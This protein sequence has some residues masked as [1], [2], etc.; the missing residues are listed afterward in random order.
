MQAGCYSIAEY[1]AV[2]VDSSTDMV[3]S[4]IFQCPV[5]SF[6]DNMSVGARGGYMVYRPVEDVGWLLF[7]SRV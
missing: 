4:M 5:Y 6:Y 3:A 2:S 1:L 7:S